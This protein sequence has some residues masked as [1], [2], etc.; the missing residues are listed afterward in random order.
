MD[1]ATSEWL[2]AAQCALRTGLTVRALRV[3]ENYGLITP[4]R[5]AAGWRRYGAQELTKL[6]EIGLL[7]V[8]GLTLNQI[9]DLTRRPSS[10]MLRQLLELQLDSWKH[11][12]T[13][14]ERG[15]SVA[16]AALLQLR[17]GRSLSVESLC[18]LIRSFEMATSTAEAPIPTVDEEVTPDVSTLDRYVG[19][20]FRNRA[21]GVSTITRRDTTLLLEPT[22]QPVLELEQTGEADFA[23]PKVD[24]VLHFE[25]IDEGAAQRLAIWHRGIAL[26]LARTDAETARAIKQTIADR[27]QGRIPAP[28]SREALREMLDTGRAGN[29]NFGQMSP[30]CAQVVR[31]QMPYW[32]IVGQYLGAIESIE[33]LRVSNQG[34]D[35]YKVQHENDLHQYRIAMGDDGKVYGFSEASATADRRAV[36]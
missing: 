19:C 13:E 7:K 27:I 30:E 4:G 34:W 6:N 5:S 11:R 17:A 21:L 32:Q 9:R 18:S 1:E 26:R 20:Y 22:G 28:G 25:Q 35:I 3:Y 31:A 15:Q 10:P 12:R 33:F 8:L 36:V 16:E 24:L 23:I 29:P 14:A 2:T